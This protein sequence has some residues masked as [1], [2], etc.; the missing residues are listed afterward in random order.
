MFNFRKKKRLFIACPTW[1]IED[2]IRKSTKDDCYFI[3]TL[4]GIYIEDELFIDQ[5]VHTI[6]NE[7]IQKLSVIAN[8]DCMFIKNLIEP[9]DD[10][11]TEAEE[12]MT[13]IYHKKYDAI[14]SLNDQRQQR[15][16][17]AYYC[18]QFSL[19]RILQDPKF[20]IN[21]QEKRLKTGILTNGETI[22]I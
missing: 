6:K 5:L 21:F 20:Q 17:L 11:E 13:W 18:A 8:A 7:G 14:R 12:V 15:S 1:H 22:Q 2:K 16:A 3:N 19:G 10:L 4:G 9:Q